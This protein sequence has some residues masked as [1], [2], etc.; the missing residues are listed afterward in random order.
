MKML[1]N[2]TSGLR[3]SLGLG[4]VALALSIVPAGQ[5]S[6]VTSISISDYG[7]ADGMAITGYA[8]FDPQQLIVSET[9]TLN[10]S[11]I[12]SSAALTGAHDP[13]MIVRTD[14][15]YF[16]K[17]VDVTGVDLGPGGD[18][19][20]LHFDVLNHTGADWSDYHLRFYSVDAN[21]IWTPF[22]GVPYKTTASD[23]LG[24]MSWTGFQANYTPGSV[25]VVQ[26]HENGVTGYYEI[27]GDISLLGQKNVRLGIE[28][29]PT[30]AVPEPNSAMLLG[31]GGLIGA[32]MLRRKYAVEA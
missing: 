8:N 28:Q 15:S 21:D 6:A 9:V 17:I 14:G 11:K 12:V 25:P 3:R 24:I 10:N 32:V 22:N 5:A 26:S 13:Y 7:T 18:V 19:I 23:Q 16:K 2:S 1:K 27:S 29:V 4:L 20:T 31:I 30:T